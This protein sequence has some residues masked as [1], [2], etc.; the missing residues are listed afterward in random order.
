MQS[1]KYH[2]QST[3]TLHVNAP[4]PHA[5]PPAPDMVYV[6]GRPYQRLGTIGKGGS[7]VVRV[8]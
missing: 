8:L 2:A 4:P 5:P 3:P 6:N 1:S 7:C